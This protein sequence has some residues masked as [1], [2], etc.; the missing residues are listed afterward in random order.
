M[1]S[2]QSSFA[3]RFRRLSRL[4]GSSH[5]ELSTEPLEQ[6]QMLSAAPIATSDT[7]TTLI[8][9]T[10]P[11]NVLA[12]DVDPDG[13]LD[14]TSVAIVSGPNNGNAVVN[15]QNGQILYTPNSGFVGQET[16]LYTVRDNSGDLSNVASVAIDVLANAPAPVAMDDLTGTQEDTPVTIR[17]LD[18]DLA[19][20]SPIAPSTVEI[21][22]PTTKGSLA[23]NPVTGVVTYTPDANVFGVGLDGDGFSYRVRNTA[24]Q[25][26][27]IAN[28]VIGITPVGDPPLTSDDFAVVAEDSVAN[29]INPLVN[30]VAVDGSIAPATLTIVNG[31]TNGIVQIVGGGLTYTPNAN[32]NGSDLFTYIVANDSG[33]FSLPATVNIFVVPA[34]DA[35]VAVNDQGQLFENTQTVFNVLANDF[36]VDGQIDPTSVMIF[37]QP[38]N[39]VATVDPNSGAI[40]YTPTAGFFG[41]DSLTYFVRDDN[42]RVSNFATLS[43]EVLEVNDLPVAANDMAFMIEDGGPLA[44][45]IL[46]NDFDPNGTIVPSTV[47]LQSTTAN[48]SLSINPATG[49]ATYTPTLN[50]NGIDTFSYRV[51]DNDGGFSNVATVTITVQSVNDA[52]VLLDDSVVTPVNTPIVIPVSSLGFDVDGT[53]DF[54]TLNIVQNVTNGNLIVNNVTGELTY[55]PNPGFGGLDLFTFRVRDNEGA[56]SNLATVDIRVGEA[57]TISGSVYVDLNDNGFRE[58]GEAGIPN[59]QVT[60]R[61]VDGPVTFTEV[62][63]TDANGNY[64]LSSSSDFTPLPAGVY[65]ITETQPVQFQDGKDTPGFPPPA[66]PVTNDEFSLITIPSGVNASGY[67][68]GERGLILNFFNMA[69]SGRFFASTV[70]PDEFNVMGAAPSNLNLA[71]GNVWLALNDGWDG[72]LDLS[73]NYNPAQGSVSMR[74][75]DANLNPVLSTATNTGVEFIHKA[76]TPGTPYIVELAGTNPHVSLTAVNSVPQAPVLPVDREDSVGTHN[77]ST[78]TFFLRYSN[79]TGVADATPFNYGA[80]NSNWIPIVGDWNG[81]GIDTAGMY[82]PTS[83]TFYLRNGNDSGTPDAGTFAY[84]LPG[85]V[86]VAGDWN[87]DGIDTIGVYNPATAT[88]FLR[89]SNSSGVAD[90]TPFNYGMPNWSP[91]AGDWNG[92][93][94]DTMGVYNSATA[95]F[96]LRNSNTSGVADV[97]A[98]NYG[99]AG[100]MAIA[101]DWNGDGFDTVGTYNIDTATYFLRNSNTSGNADVA[102]INFGQPGWYPIVGNWMHD[103][104]SLVAA[105][106]EVQSSAVSEKLSTDDLMPVLQEAIGRW[107]AAGIDPRGAELL[108]SVDVQ[109]VDLAGAQLG[110]ASGN[111]ILLDSNAAGHGW[112]VDSTLSDDDEFGLLAADGL[113]ATGDS[114]AAGRIDLLTVLA[115]ELGHMLGLPDIANHDD[116]VMN[117]SLA[118]GVRRTPTAAEADA[119]FVVRKESRIFVRVI[120]KNTERAAKN[121]M[122]NLRKNKLGQLNSRQHRTLEAL[123]ERRLLAIEPFQSGFNIDI[124]P[125][126]NLFDGD[127]PH[128]PGALFAINRAVSIWESVI[129]DPITVTIEIDIED[130]SPFSYIVEN[131]FL[132]SDFNT[133]RNAMIADGVPEGDEDILLS[134]PTALEFNASLPRDFTLIPNQIAVNKANAKALG[135]P[136]INGQLD[137]VDGTITLDR[138]RNAVDDFDGV[139]WDFDDRDGIGVDAFGFTQRSFTAAVTSAIGNV[140]GFRSS[141]D[142]IGPQIFALEE[143]AFAPTVLDLFRFENTAAGFD[144]ATPEDFRTF[145]RQLTP[146]SDHIFDDTNDEW[147]LDSDTIGPLLT[148]T[149]WDSSANPPIGVMQGGFFGEAG[150]TY[151]IFSRA[152]WRA[153]DLIGWDIE[154]Q[155]L[156]DLVGDSFEVVG[157]APLQ[158]GESI[159]IEFAIRNQ[160]EAIA[161]PFNVGFFIFDSNV[162]FNGRTYRDLI[163]AG[164]ADPIGE[165]DFEGMLPFDTSD[166]LRTSLELPVFSPTYTFGGVGDYKIGMV[167]DPNAEVFELNEFNNTGVGELFDFETVFLSP[168][169]F[170]PDVAGNTFDITETEAGTGEEV[171]VTFDISNLGQGQAEAFQVNVLLSRDNQIG[172]GDFVL[173]TVNIS[174][175]ERNSDSDLITR[176]FTLPNVNHPIWSINGSGNYYIGVL[177]DANNQL[178]EANELNNSGLGL[179]IDYDVIDVT[180]SDPNDPPPSPNPDMRGIVFDAITDPATAGSTATVNFK[181]D[182][183]GSQNASQFTVDFYLSTNSTIT[184]DDFFLGQRVISGIESGKSTA[185][186]TQL[187]Q[188]P[189]AGNA[190]WNGTGT[191]YIGMVIDRDNNIVESNES[192]NSNRGVLLDKDSLT[193]TVPQVPADLRG[194]NFNVVQEPLEAGDSFDLQFTVQ[195]AAAGNAGPFSVR[196]YLSS[197]SLINS[198]DRLIGQFSF[199]GL[200]GN[201]SQANS[202]NLTLPT[203]AILYGNGDNTYYIGMIVDAGGAVAESN[204]NNNSNRGELVDFDSVI[205]TLPSLGGQGNPGFNDTIGAYNPSTGTFFLRNSND[206][207]DADIDAFNIGSGGN[208]PITGDWNGDGVDTT[209]VYDP[210]TATF[211]LINDNADGIPVDITFAFGMP[212]WVPLAGDWNGDGIDT[213]GVYNP[214]TATFFLKNTNSGGVADVPAFN[215]GMPGWTPIVGDWD[216]NSTD[217]VGLYNAAT[218]TFFLR[219]SNSSGVADVPAFNY[220]IPNWVP[221]AGDWNN[222]GI[223]TIGVHNSATATSFLRNS[224]DS[225]VADVTPFNYGMPGWVPLAGRWTDTVQPLVAAQG[226]SSSPVNAPSLDMADVQTLLSEAAGKWAAAGLNANG[227]ATLASADIRI[228]DLPGATLG[229]VVNDRLYLD[230]NAAGHGWFVDATPGVDEEYEL[231]ASEG[232]KATTGP[233]ADGID[234]LSVIA[235]EFGHLLGLDDHADDPDD[236]MYESIARGERRNPTAAEVDEIFA[237]EL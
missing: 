56:L 231:L 47:A 195:N 129:R 69:L 3:S 162:D 8:N 23:V 46:S 102:P 211:R 118:E 26:S 233:A 107:I 237:G 182:N 163:S 74:L 225:G 85:W 81:D 124:I 140:L 161:G 34:N 226:V 159:D 174:G 183:N 232:L 181:L 77:P 218:A 44:I 93:G 205:I 13:V 1:R 20:G 132:P 224:N 131:E 2:R 189:G 219:N 52:P 130:I 87:G 49:V 196:F 197:N 19:I 25:V 176:T 104:A 148:V 91:I 67:N 103:G 139:S 88:F 32:Y 160:S 99:I 178:I 7:A 38:D 60:I 105:A 24:G 92:D 236:L 184:T 79:D 126:D 31:P 193:I 30:D 42:G 170:P 213:I 68:F 221:L 36:D 143:T 171:T 222:D 156:S 145:P 180:V 98:F 168:V 97:P 120:P 71:N 10:V 110:R 116:A 121:K 208:I 177:S 54:S 27:N 45:N 157:S 220:G 17:I 164:L 15:P 123:E 191:Y 179:G 141:V 165:F 70:T 94:I 114:P 82:D 62:V 108:S 203:D 111:R 158:A 112:F 65:T 41:N 155:P 76:N 128:F 206:S 167:I 229:L 216:G 50:F 202:V 212:G 84:G 101:G 29:P 172:A 35:P 235:H 227:I 169:P 175:L 138:V 209:G 64:S 55:V 127:E 228:A 43:I 204:E 75:L 187:L 201:S 153:L 166:I 137:G 5:R 198:S 39:G 154:S 80:G 11:V 223:D 152:D 6:R 199:N 61:K 136:N 146:G 22:T 12:N 150:N 134:L 18:N 51:Q 96:F 133:I 40:F 59:T 214:T 83:A 89:N 115:H 28:V 21:M 33:D 95:T 58:A 186:L 113:Q 48:G 230:V 73:A 188:L 117:E 190:F 100:W 135:L 125:G 210:T 217:T 194:T 66:G 215:Y 173:G 122:R 151:N 90:V 63:F 234:L 16:I 53:L 200:A 192:N 57:I 142:I 119:A 72:T 147:R 14:P 207:G 86:P 4:Q 37:D 106:G 149:N 144:P 109:V 78:A 9:T 185:E